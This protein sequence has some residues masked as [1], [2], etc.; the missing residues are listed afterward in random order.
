MSGPAD[1]PPPPQ[2][3]KKRSGCMTALIVLLVL[4]GISLVVCCG[5]F[6]LVGYQFQKAVVEEPA[7]V[8]ALK[9]EIAQVTLPVGMEPKG[10]INGTF[11]FVGG[12]KM[13]MFEGENNSFFALGEVSGPMAASA[14]ET[15]RQEIEKQRAEQ[16]PSEDQTTEQVEFT[17]R[18][19]PA[20]ME[21]VR[22]TKSDGTQKVEV[23]GSFEGHEGPAFIAL[24]LDGE[25]YDD[26]KIRELIESIQ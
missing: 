16:Q 15:F 23:F 18:G 2:L 7:A 13:V 11:P 25:Q 26:A 1:F 19:Q 20:Q 5:G 4:G 21:V 3:P 24:S 12:I 14:Q 9:D 8:Q 10:G 17:V 22:G 6:A